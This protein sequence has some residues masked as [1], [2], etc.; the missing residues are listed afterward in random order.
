MRIKIKRLLSLFLTLALLMQI[1]PASAFAANFGEKDS[2]APKEPVRPNPMDSMYYQGSK[3]EYQAEDVLCELN[4]R[5]T[6]TEK[7]F[8]LANG[9]D[10]AISYAYP[11][12]YEDAQGEY[13]EIDNSLKLYNADGTLSTAAVKS[14]LAESSTV[15]KALAIDTRVYKNT[16]GIAQV[17]LA[18]SGGADK[19]ASITY[20][21]YTVSLTPQVIT[22]ASA[23][24][25]ASGDAALKAAK[26]A[27]RVKA[28]ET[29]YAKDSF[30]AKV[31]PQNLSSALVYEDIIAGA[32]L[33]YIVAETSLK[34]NIIV[35]SAAAPNS[36][37]FLLDAGGLKPVQTEAGSIEL[38]DKNKKTVFVIPAGNMVDANGVMSTEVAY[39]LKAVTGGKYILTVT[40]DAQWLKAEDRSYPVTIDPPVYIQGFYN[41][42]TG[43]LNQYYGS[44]PSGQQ[45][46]EYIGGFSQYGTYCRMLVRVNSLP[47][48]PNNSQVVRSALCL[49]K[50]SYSYV[51][52][53]S[54]RLQAQALKKNTPVN[55]YWCMLHTWN[56][57][58][59]VDTEV[60]D[61][62][63]V[64]AGS[65]YA[66]WDLTKETRKWYNDPST[67]YGICLRATMEGLMD[68]SNCANATFYSSNTT[69]AAYRPYFAIEYRNNVGLESYYSYQTHGIDRAGAGYI[70]DYTGHLTIL[71]NDVSYAGTVNPVSINHVYNSSN[72]SVDGNSKY[73]SMKLGKGWMLDAQQSIADTT[74][75][76]LAYVD[77]DGTIHFFP[78][79]G[80]TYKDEDGLGLTITYDGTNY[81]LRDKKD[82]ISFFPDGVL[83][84]TQDANGNRVTYTRNASNQIISVSRTNAGADSELIATLSYDSGGY[85]TSITD[86][87]GNV[88]RY[89]YDSNGNLATVTHPDNTTVSYTYD[90][91]GKLI[92]AKDNESGYS[93]NYEYNAYTGKISKFYEKAGTVTGAGVQADGSFNGIQTYR[94]CGP[95][96]VLGNAD[97]VISHTIQDLWGRTI[98]SYSTNADGTLIYGA[99]SAAYT[100]NSGVNANNNR[101]LVSST[102]GIQSVN[103][104]KYPSLDGIS[105]LSAGS[106]AFSGGGS[107]V[108][109]A[110][111]P[112]TGNQSAKLTRA[113]SDSSSVL[114]QTVTG[115]DTSK[116]YVLSAY[117]NTSEVTSFGSGKVSIK[118]V[119]AQTVEG[120]AVNWNTSGV[121]DGWER[122][123]VTAQPNTSGSITLRIEASALAGSVYID[124]LQAEISLFGEDGTPGAASLLTNGSMRDNG[125]WNAWSTGYLSYVTDSKFGRAMK[126]SGSSYEGHDV[127]QDI[128]INKPGTQT[129][130]LSGWGKAAAVPLVDGDTR[131]FSMWVEIYYSDAAGTVE[132]QNLEFN[133]DTTQWQ[134]MTLPIVPKH[135]ELNVMGMRVYFT[136]CRNPNTAYF[137]N[138]SLTCEDA[139]SYKYNSDGELVSV[140]S[141][142]NET[143]TY[144][145]SGADLISQVTGGNGTFSY[146]YDNKHNV[147][148]AT[149]DG[150][151]MSV[152]Y[153]GKG[154]A[155]GTTL[156]G[157]D[158]SST[159]SSSAA[160]DTNGN[161]VTSQTDARG[162]SI[163]YAYANN[164]SKQIG[165]PTSVTDAN[166]VTQTS[167]YYAN[168][169]RVATTGISGG[170]SVTY[171]YSGGRLSAM[172]RMGGGQSQSYLLSY[173]GFGNMTGVNVGNRNLASYTYG[174]ANGLLSQMSYGN[175]ASIRY[176]YDELERVSSVYYNNSST[177]SVSYAYSGN[178]ELSKVEDIAANRERDY[179]YDSL[180]RLT[181]M[182]ERSGSSGVQVFRSQ[183]DGSNR[184]TKNEYTVSPAWNGV[185]RDTRSYCYAYDDSDGSL[186][187]MTLPANGSYTYTYDALKRLNTRALKLNNSAFINRSYSYLP[188]SGTNATTMLV[189]GVT[190]S[191]ANGS[192]ISSYTYGYDN[193]GNITSVSGSTVANYSYDNLGQLRTE[194][195]GGKTYTYSYDTAGNIVSVTD[196]TTTKNYVYGDSSWKDLLTSY[197]GASIN[198]D[199]IGNPTKWYDGTNFTWVNGRRLASAV[200]SSTGINNSY[201]YD[202]DGLRLTKTVNGVQHRY[203]W[204]GSQLVAEYYGGTE[205]EFFYDESGAPYAF[206]YKANAS[207][208]P[209]MYYYVTNLQGDVTNIVDASGNVNSTYTYNAW[210]KLIFSAGTMSAINPLRYRGYYYDAETEL[211]Y[212]QSRY[213][214]P[215]ICRFV[216]ADNQ[217]ATGNITGLNLF[218]YCGNNPVNTLDPTG[219]AGWHWALGAAVVAACAVAT[220]VTCGM[221]V[222]TAF[223]AVVLVANGMAATTTASTIAAAAFIGSAT[224]YGM[225]AL[226]A[227]STSNSV[228]E[229]NAQGNWGTVAATAGGA[230]INGA[231]AYAA[232]R[233]PTTTVYRSVGTAE[234]QDIKSTG[235]FNLVRG[236]MES[237]QFGFNLDETRQFGNMMKQETIVSAKVPNSM[238]N[239]LYTGGVDTSIFRAGTLTVYG[240]QLD[241]FNQAVSGTIRFLP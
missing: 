112:H 91:N 155:T 240:E 149:N 53:T 123:Y 13:K 54:L 185:F 43:T 182:T 173:D 20:D 147:T 119:G 57:C 214:D 90:S 25:S 40:A 197:N 213:Y 188:G 10:L 45:A 34:E 193:V 27:G 196:G 78:G 102:K 170:A 190:N 37:A 219:E 229:F 96:R 7:H 121:G 79:S 146:E 89:S 80:S 215:E 5:R 94:Y 184:V 26:V 97:D 220:V 21:G 198:Y 99:D 82:N 221:S 76:Y 212:L 206:S 93:M 2:T 191:R 33:E 70:G 150:L 6:Q 55:G 241:A 120:S 88:T 19:L 203:V 116:W 154:N 187:S 176:D 189:S 73:G 195:Y 67:N 28:I 18:L 22:S 217:L 60:I 126:V 71:K 141:S 42:E 41:I 158:T 202:A 117:V 87:V 35:K 138:F 222:V 216:N 201:T 163:T 174:S 15:G 30:E 224:V 239:Q 52:M 179:N 72:S 166:N 156:S 223:T 227:A 75:G 32:D 151:T 127:Y 186:A 118:A 238:L 207:T 11:V 111:K 24:T 85:L 218:A 132:K 235:R 181:S 9:S 74:F 228:Q 51:G 211:Y 98:S 105:S 23:I 29:L 237:K 161:L 168:N 192:N 175:G 145:Y 61:Y 115:L 108:L 231:A 131:S 136:F 178:G 17:R 230:L 169:G 194:T 1:F 152:S 65:S 58:P 106:W 107:G 44:S 66:M 12:H 133:A 16:S 177:P 200:N 139:Q 46:I 164:L 50:D 81:V 153:D 160:Y 62:T 69:N 135:P 83:S 103:L 208:T 128:Y 130:L 234:A 3:P 59:E 143:Q 183:Y 47:I 232:T 134:Y 31:I 209:V 100:V 137:T 109:A 48:I 122:I 165:Q 101:T 39:S 199:G 36:Y 225:A 56:N 159:I 236:G 157:T 38:Q 113:V 180:G 140:T 210:G 95:D 171:V 226:S 104:L 64:S 77:G 167:S 114:S 92:S 49:Y 63:D 148:K 204:Q 233:T 205:L 144:S 4:E 84:Y 124:D 86:G 68:Y 110:N 129:Y 142:E 125:Y 8:R 14:G 172:H 162:K